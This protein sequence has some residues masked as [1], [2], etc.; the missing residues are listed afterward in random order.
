MVAFVVVRRNT[1][2][3]LRYALARS[4]AN[5]IVARAPH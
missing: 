4:G 1:Q 3:D 5:P 2:V